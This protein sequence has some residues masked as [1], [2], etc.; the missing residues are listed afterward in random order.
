MLAQPAK[1]VIG[2]QVGGVIARVA[3]R[4][5]NLGARDRSAQT[6]DE[7]DNGPRVEL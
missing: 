4:E 1:R 7:I 5:L 6:P 3:C 2:V